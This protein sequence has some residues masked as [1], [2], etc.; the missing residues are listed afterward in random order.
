[1]YAPALALLVITLFHGLTTSLVFSE[2]VWQITLLR[3][4]GSEI[5]GQWCLAPLAPQGHMMRFLRRKRKK[6]T[7]EPTDNVQPTASTIIV[8]RKTITK[9]QS[10]GNQT[11]LNQLLALSPTAF[12][13]AVAR[14]LPHLGYREARRTGGAGDLGVDIVCYDDH[15]GLVAVQ[16]KRYGSGNKVTSPNIANF[17]GMMVHHGAR[18]GIYVTTSGFTRAGLELANT[19]DI[20]T[21]DGAQLAAHFAAHPEALGIHNPDPPPRPIESRPEKHRQAA[22]RPEAWSY[23]N[24]DRSRRRP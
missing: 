15:G 2:A 21:I 10:H 9:V 17:F 3:G 6:V 8:G 24:Q 5:L 23:S 7:R 13:H 20:K 4:G 12:E 1:M 22:E 18:Q 19:R 14:L 11:I 16:C